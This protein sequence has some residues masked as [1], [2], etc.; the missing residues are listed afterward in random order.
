MGD[1]KRK[2]R[3]N[4]TQRDGQE[5]LQ[6]FHVKGEKSEV[7]FTSYINQ[8]VWF[9]FG[10]G[11][12]LRPFAAPPPTAPSPSCTEAAGRRV[13]QR[14]GRPTAQDLQGVPQPGPRPGALTAGRGATPPNSPRSLRHRGADE[15]P[16]RPGPPPRGRHPAPPRR[17]RAPGP[18]SSPR[19]GT[20]D[21]EPVTGVSARLGE[22]GCEPAGQVTPGAPA[23]GT[24][25]AAGRGRHPDDIKV[26]ESQTRQQ[27]ATS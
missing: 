7:V 19:P 5:I 27:S 16:P 2:L 21:S 8:V 6:P 22:E 13:P 17:S 25:L 20:P 3:K 15:S 9:G 12:Q 14:T 23:R 11:S 10:F 18:P 26:R 4:G 24:H 1:K